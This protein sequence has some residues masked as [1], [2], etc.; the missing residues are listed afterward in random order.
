MGLYAQARRASN[1]VHEALPRPQ[2]EIATFRNTALTTFFDLGK[3]TNNFV[4][5]SA[6]DGYPSEAMRSDCKGCC[7]RLSVRIVQA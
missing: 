6:G 7:L 4:G 3:A 5:Q 2:S 1:Q